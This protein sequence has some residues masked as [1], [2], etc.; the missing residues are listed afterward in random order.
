VLPPSVAGIAAIRRRSQPLLGHSATERPRVALRVL[1]VLVVSR[2]EHL[3]WTITYLRSA[4]S[5]SIFRDRSTTVTFPAPTNQHNLLD[6]C[7][8]PLEMATLIRADALADAGN[9]F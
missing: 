7:T 8:A 5:P 4:A 2:R 9:A 1:S 6:C 3:S